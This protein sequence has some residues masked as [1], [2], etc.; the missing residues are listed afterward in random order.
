MLTKLDNVSGFIAVFDDTI[1]P[2]V[3]NQGS[4]QPLGS[5]EYL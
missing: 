5:L 4:G 2:V 1:R 3:P